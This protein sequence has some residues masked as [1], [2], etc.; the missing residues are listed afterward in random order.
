[1]NLT[2]ATTAPPTVLLLDD[3]AELGQM[4]CRYLGQNGFA[5]RWVTTIADFRA[6]LAQQ[7]PAL[8]LV[9]VMLPDGDGLTLARELSTQRRFALMMLSARG[10]EVDRIV[11]YEVGA[12]DYLPKPFN[13]RELLARMRA[14]LRRSV[15]PATHDTPTAPAF[16]AFSVDLAGHRLW[17][18][19][20]EVPIS[21]AEF[22]LLAV[23][24]RHPRQVL[25]RD[26]LT[27]LV[28]G[29]ER[30]PLDRSIDARVARLRKRIEADTQNPRF[31]RTVWGVGYLFD[32][33]G[34][35]P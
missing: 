2:E 22:T 12:D 26:R 6:A 8:A 18:A 32:P 16:G 5:V 13:P 9:D 11:G 19:G 20:Q 27:D 7:V 23:F 34:R 31:I 17:C 30:M 1:M 15:L 21:T 14:V 25:S 3:D 10:D 24:L 33:D 29:V 35:A 28:Q 4:L